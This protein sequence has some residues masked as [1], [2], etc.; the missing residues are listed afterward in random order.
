[1]GRYL[2][3]Y[4]AK[5]IFEQ[6]RN[7][8]YKNIKLTFYSPNRLNKFRID[9]FASKEPETL[10]WIEKFNQNSI[11]WDIGANIGIYSCYAAKLKNC[12]V[13][14]FEPSVFNLEIL[15]KNIFLN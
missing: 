4:L 5:Y 15:T 11:F 7:I 8:N 3:E 9:T 1:M 12:N 13:Y 14:A 6:K 2:T 10:G